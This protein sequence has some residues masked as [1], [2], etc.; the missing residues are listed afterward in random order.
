M[1]EQAF[2]GRVFDSGK[3]S[4]SQNAPRGMRVG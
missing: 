4:A 1:G 2:P 3:K